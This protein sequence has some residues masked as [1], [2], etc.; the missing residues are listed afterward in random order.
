MELGNRRHERREALTPYFH[1]VIGEEEHQSLILPIT[2]MAST[3]EMRP[4]QN[5]LFAIR[6]EDQQGRNRGLR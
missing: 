5:P 2:Q 3:H 6:G 4:R 1:F